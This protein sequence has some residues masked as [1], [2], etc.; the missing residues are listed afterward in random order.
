M[1][2]ADHNV[3]RKTE[4][5]SFTRKVKNIVFYPTWTNIPA[6]MGDIALL[7]LDSPV[8]YSKKV[9]PICLPWSS[10]KQTFAD[11]LGVAIGWGVTED[12][13]PSSYLRKVRS[14]FDLSKVDLDKNF[15]A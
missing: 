4:T 5:Q 15:N 11:M 3:K 12:G 8:E 7:K 9:S 2:F 10:P 13:S 1:S 6:V 14:V